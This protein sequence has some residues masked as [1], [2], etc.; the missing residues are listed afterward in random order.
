MGGSVNATSSDTNDEWVGQHF[1]IRAGTAA[2]AGTEP[3][4]SIN[5]PQVL[6][7]IPQ[8]NFEEVITLSLPFI[9]KEESGNYCQV[10]YNIP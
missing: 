4:V 1:A 10:T 5:I 8:Q 2:G 7:D 6:F 9:A 3:S